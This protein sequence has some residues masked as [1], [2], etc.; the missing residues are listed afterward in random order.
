MII[1]P[2]TDKLSCQL[3]IFHQSLTLIEERIGE[4]SFLKILPFL[5][6]S[7]ELFGFLPSFT[8]F[9][10]NQYSKKRELHINSFYY[11]FGLILFTHAF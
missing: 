7:V 5:V 3:S 11:L 1:A 9:K 10:L 6:S 2:N 4:E 8:S